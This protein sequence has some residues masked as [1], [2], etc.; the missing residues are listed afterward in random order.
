MLE[1][2]K[3]WFKFKFEVVYFYNVYGPNQISSGSMATVIGIFEDLYKKKKPLTVVKPGTQTRRFTHI[4]DTIDVGRCAPPFHKIYPGA[5]SNFPVAS[6]VDVFGIGF[7]ISP[8]K[9]Q[10]GHLRLL[11]WRHRTDS[12]DRRRQ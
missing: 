10:D 8:A 12:C 1:N 3:T 6:F 4:K 9:S 11:R 2:L 7:P 5:Y